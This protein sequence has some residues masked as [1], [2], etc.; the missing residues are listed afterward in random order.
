MFDLQL[1]SQCGSTYNCL[2]RSV[3]EIHLHVAG[4]LSN[5]PTNKQNHLNTVSIR[6][7]SLFKNEHVKFLWDATTTCHVDCPSSK[8]TQC[9]GRD[10]QILQGHKWATLSQHCQLSIYSV[11]Q[12]SRHK[13][14]A[15]STCS[16]CGLRHTTESLIMKR[17]ASSSGTIAYKAAPNAPPRVAVVVGVM[18]RMFHNSDTEEPVAADDDD[19]GDNI[20]F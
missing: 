5:Q 18:V 15:R 1:L 20:L 16:T 3:P 13:C 19:D 2:S 6:S 14:D 17:R 7:V 8:P 12:Q 10:E 4:T 9:Q 11:I